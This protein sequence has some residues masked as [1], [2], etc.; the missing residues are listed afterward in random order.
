MGEVEADH[1]AQIGWFGRFDVQTFY[2]RLAQQ[3][4]ERGL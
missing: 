4:A 1:W 2:G 3:L